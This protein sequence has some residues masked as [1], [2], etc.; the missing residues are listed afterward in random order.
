MF[1]INCIKSLKPVLSMEGTSTNYEGALF[2]NEGGNF[3]M[4]HAKIVI[5]EENW[6]EFIKKVNKFFLVKKYMEVNKD[7]I[8]FNRIRGASNN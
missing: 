2:Y 6:E 1:D 3:T 5:E 7:E 4:V 8:R